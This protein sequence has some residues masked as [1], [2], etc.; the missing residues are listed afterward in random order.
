MLA[1]ARDPRQCVLDASTT[2]TVDPADFPLEDADGRRYRHLPLRNTN[3]KFNP[4]TART[5]HFPVW[6]DPESGR[7]SV[8][9]STAPRR[10]SP[11]SATAGRRCGG[12]R[13]R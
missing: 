4:V 12:G 11:S 9:L 6:G 10:S 5:L 3:K 8:T 2:E 13:R 7:V 1:Y